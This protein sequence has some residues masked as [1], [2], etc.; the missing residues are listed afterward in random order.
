M[1]KTHRKLTNIILNDLYIKIHAIKIF[2]KPSRLID[3]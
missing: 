2:K 3:N 1:Y